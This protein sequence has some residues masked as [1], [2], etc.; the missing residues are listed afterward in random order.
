MDAGIFLGVKGP[1]REAPCFAKVKDVELCLHI[2]VFFHGI[3]LN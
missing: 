2:S 1:A 3:M